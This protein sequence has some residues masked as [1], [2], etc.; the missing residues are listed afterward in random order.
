MAKS[1]PLLE[2]E[3]PCCEAI[4]KVD[5]TTG[6]VISH[7]AKEKPPVI[8]DIPTA[9]ARLKEE[10]ARRDQKFEKSVADQKNRQDILSKKFDELFKQAKENPDIGPPPKDIDL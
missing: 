6:T 1:S 7:K 3:C 8:D 5:P 10:A 9:V 2:V 4:L